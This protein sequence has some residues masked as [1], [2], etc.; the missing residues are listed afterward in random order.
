MNKTSSGHHAAIMLCAITLMACQ[1]LNEVGRAPAFSSPDHSIEHA[2]L[3]RVPLP[4]SADP[5]SPTAPS[6]LWSV[7]QRSLLGDRRAGGQGDIMTVVIEINDS[8]E[9]SN[10]TSR[11]RTGSS[12]MGIPQ[13]FGLPQAIDSKNEGGFSIGAG[14]ETNSGSSF[15]GNGSV[16]RNEKLTLRVASTVVEVLPN[17]VM[18]IEGRQEVRVNHE[19][20]ELLVTGYV[21]PTDISRQNEITYD[22]I[23]GARISYGGRGVIST[24][25]QPRYGQQIIDILAPF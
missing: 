13:F 3:Y 1:P 2:A 19:L 16:R 5:R 20:R 25:Q 15:S 21:R 10:N 7:G 18:R 9:I 22:K 11:G 23:A 17:G 4:E 6:S 8:A 12:S 24:M 14:I